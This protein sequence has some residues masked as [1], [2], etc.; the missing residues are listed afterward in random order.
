MTAVGTEGPDWAPKF[1]PCE[2]PE[3]GHSSPRE[4]P[5]G[6]LEMSTHDRPGPAML[7]GS[8]TPRAASRVLV[9]SNNATN[10]QT[11]GYTA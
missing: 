10:F 8:T 6:R 5:L 9:G 1:P 3:I 2:C 11:M 7:K 4:S